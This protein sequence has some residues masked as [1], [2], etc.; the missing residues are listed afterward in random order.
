MID[1]RALEDPLQR[2]PSFLQKDSLLNNIHIAL[3]SKSLHSFVTRIQIR[4]SLPLSVSLYRIQ[5]YRGF[6][7][8]ELETGR[9]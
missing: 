6:P 2:L 3:I 4:S 5:E 7:C 1:E 8:N 9:G